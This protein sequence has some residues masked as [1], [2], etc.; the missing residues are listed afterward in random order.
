M[1]KVTWIYSKLGSY[2][3]SPVECIRLVG[4]RSGLGGPGP[5][6]GLIVTRLSSCG[7]CSSCSRKHGK[8]VSF[9]NSQTS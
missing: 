8:R 1:N 2:W 5:G 7:D 4:V 9:I 3:A 6:P